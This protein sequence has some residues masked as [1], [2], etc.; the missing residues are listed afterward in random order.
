MS[1]IHF[2]FYAAFQ[3]YMSISNVYPN[4]S[5]GVQRQVVIVTILDDDM[6]EASE[7][8]NIALSVVSTGGASVMI[9]TPMATVEIINDDR[10]QQ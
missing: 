7:T 10:K 1:G 4:F 9:S 8:F 5:S 6:F 3:D 2:I